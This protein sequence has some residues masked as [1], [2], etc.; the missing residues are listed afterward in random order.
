M[1]LGIAFLLAGCIEEPPFRHTHDD[2]A[3]GGAGDAHGRPGD[4]TLAMDGSEDVVLDLTSGAP[5]EFRFTPDRLTVDRG[6]RVGIRLQNDGGLEHEFALR[7]EGVH[8]HA[9]PGGSAS[10]AFIAPAPGEYTFGCYIPGHFEVGMRGT[11]V[12]T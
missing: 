8:I 7:D 10:G 2:G 6:D 5:S 9:A 11:L 3:H 4:G 1:L 12:V